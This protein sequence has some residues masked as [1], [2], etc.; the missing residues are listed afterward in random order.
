MRIGMGW[1]RLACQVAFDIT[2]LLIFMSFATFPRLLRG[3]CFI[4][5]A[6]FNK[7]N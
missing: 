6:M 2:A 3:K 1:A 4:C 7:I 5:I